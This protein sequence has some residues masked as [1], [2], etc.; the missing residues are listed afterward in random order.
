[1][2]KYLFLLFLF[3]T[4]WSFAIVHTTAPT[5]DQTISIDRFVNSSNKDLEKEWDVDL[6]FKEKATLWL[7]KKKLKKAIKK[8]LELA[9]TKLSH[10]VLLQPDNREVEQKGAASLYL[11]LLGGVAILFLGS[12]FGSAILGL[13]TLISMILSISSLSKHKKNPEKYKGKWMP[14]TALILLG[15]VLIAGAITFLGG[16]SLGT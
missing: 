12:G 9:S 1:M 15:V 5:S 3:F 13:L 8:N 14:I 4:H 6:S 10:K 7:M 16:L 2:K 11:L